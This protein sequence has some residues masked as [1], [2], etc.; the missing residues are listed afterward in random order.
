MMALHAAL[1]AWA[2]QASGKQEK[3]EG[4]RDLC[5]HGFSRPSFLNANPIDI[6][7]WRVLCGGALLSIIRRLSSIPGL[8]PPGAKMPL[9]MVKCAQG[10]L[11]K[12]ILGQ[13]HS[14]RGEVHEETCGGK[15][16]RKA[17]ETRVWGESGELCFQYT[18]L[19][20][21]SQMC[22]LGQIAPTFRASISLS[23]EW[24]R[25]GHIPKVHSGSLNEIMHLKTFCFKKKFECWFSHLSFL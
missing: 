4:G 12:G 18:V 20:A 5:S 16:R 25:L 14:W 13:G 1:L 19:T 3:T 2:T 22:D 6:L 17:C 24:R 11:N 9:G 21:I 15:N 7:G 23:V 8:H 10:V